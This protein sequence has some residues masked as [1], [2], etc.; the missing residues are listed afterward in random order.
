MK[1]SSDP[2]YLHEQKFFT[3]WLKSIAKEWPADDP[4]EQE[5]LVALFHQQVLSRMYET[6]DDEDC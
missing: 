4:I 1:N 2:V 3:D 6:E 5:N